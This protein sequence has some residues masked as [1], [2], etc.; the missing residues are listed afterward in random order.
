[1][2]L[3]AEEAAELD[4]LLKDPKAK[5]GDSFRTQALEQVTAFKDQGLEGWA[6]AGGV[7]ADAAPAV[8]GE[9]GLKGIIGQEGTGGQAAAEAEAERI[10]GQ[11]DPRFSLVP[12]VL[13]LQPATTH[14]EGDE[15]AAR[16]WQAGQKDA[17]IVYEPPLAVV[18][19]QLLENPALVRALRPD[20]P[21][22]MDEIT[23]LTSGSPLYQDAANYMYRQSAEA[24]AKSGR[25][26][27][28]YSELPWLQD[29]K[30][31]VV[32]TLKLKLG[33]ALPEAMDATDAFVLGVDDT[34]TFGAGRAAQEA[35]SPEDTDPRVP[36]MGINET[37]PQR[38]ADTNA[39]KAA[40]HSMAYGAGQALGMLSSWAPS[41]LLW[42]GLQ[43]GGGLAV[44]AAAKTRLGAAAANLAPSW[45]KG[46][47]GIAGDA[48]IGGAA[49]AGT[50]AAQE[51]V[52]AAAR[53]QAPDMAE[54]GERVRDVGETGAYLGGGGSALGRL[55]HAG[56]EVI[57]DSDRYGGNVRRTEPNMD[58]RARSIVTGP[59]LNPETK[60]LRKEAKLGGYQPG[61]ILAEEMAEPVRKAAA[62]N[63]A[64]AKNRSRSETANYSRTPEGG[65]EL[66][67][68]HLQS[69]SLEK[70]RDHH[71]PKA[72]GGLHAVDDKYRPA[73]K[74]FNSL[75]EDVSLE[76][77]KG[78]TKLDPDEAGSFLSGR[79]RHKL[80]KADLDAA[81]AKRNATPIDR[82]AYLQTLDPKKRALVN[83]EIEASI[84]DAFK[85]RITG[86]ATD[87][88]IDA[89]SAEY[90]AAEQQAL[91]EFVDA[92][93]VL[94]PFGGSLGD[95]LRKRGVDAV[96]VKPQNYDAR[97]TETLL[98]GLA[99]PDLV[100]A[101]KFDRQRRPLDGKKGG[102]AERRQRH[103]DDISKAEAV[104]KDVA[105]GG[106][107]FKPIAG[108]YQSS[109]GEKQLVDRVKG[110]AD[111][112]GVRNKLDRLRG[113]QS[114]L[115]LHNRARFLGPDG[116]SRNLLS[117]TNWYDA[118]QLRAFPALKALEGPL[119]PLRGGN[120]GR[121]ALLG[122]EEDEAAAARDESTSRGRYQ[123]DRE[124][125]LKELEE[126]KEKAR[127][128]R[129]RHRT[130]RHR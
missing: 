90:K 88:P 56:A 34:A 86:N 26:I 93:V 112:S 82:R 20:A 63:T 76:P 38:T 8:P 64:A 3:T 91:R 68:T 6:K 100:E 59:G 1:M 47:A 84:D 123:A 62:Q 121:G 11:L 70:L 22:E 80:L 130:E 116:Q 71:Q 29:D 74:V 78:A 39:W 21:P 45:V 44:R 126:D 55:A 72:G 30:R 104:E 89:R 87:K 40:D 37:A 122:N 77:V 16:D 35:L 102:W 14:P 114:T 17:V 118:G 99:D 15:A 128:E 97:R 57:R 66:P 107:A 109:P 98:D 51:G 19:K 27:L 115:A 52:D 46:A 67:M 124:R 65:A 79:W 48:A 73:Q 81:A 23:G 113:L 54:A 96:Y 53:G 42:Q 2:A 117:P 85:D 33:A 49:S 4:R 41:N 129:Q 101:A 108:L 83:E 50:Q 7:K 103:A 110:L 25:K 105:P 60:A 125:R 28:R 95:Y 36:R 61:D 9:L 31:G 5:I 92:E 111:Q 32:D 69:M 119:G 10:A 13:A 120:P 94:E 24:A 18:R 12:Q 75:V 43:E 58:W 127:K 106:D